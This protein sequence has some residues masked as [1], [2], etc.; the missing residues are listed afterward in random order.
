MGL[1]GKK[2]DGRLPA[3]SAT[4]VRA[5]NCIYLG[6]PF[7]QRGERILISSIE[8]EFALDPVDIPETWTELAEIVRT[9]TS[10]PRERRV[11]VNILGTTLGM[12]DQ[13][14]DALCEAV[15]APGDASEIR[16]YLRGGGNSV[17]ATKAPLVARPSGSDYWDFEVIKIVSLMASPQA[18]QARESG[19]WAY[20]EVWAGDAGAFPYP[21]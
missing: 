9:R 2:Q 10:E 4:A 15:G 11:L 12:V 7:P 14:L 13:K 19:G 20:P 6:E 8:V 1:F 3:P 16:T 18:R 5:G 17:E 21:Y